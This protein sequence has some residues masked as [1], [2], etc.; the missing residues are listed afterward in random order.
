M[1]TIPI[2]PLKG[3]SKYEFHKRVLLWYQRLHGDMR[4]PYDFVM[5]WVD[6]WPEEMWDVKLGGLVGRIRGGRTWN[7]NKEDLA[8]IA[9]RYDKQQ[10]GAPGIDWE[11][12]KLAS[13]TF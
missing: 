4:V 11:T 9:F 10:D 6:E 8:S 3:E 13:E 12:L 7:N 1:R 2:G 5:Q